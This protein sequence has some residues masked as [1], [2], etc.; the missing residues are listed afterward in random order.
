MNKWQQLTSLTALPLLLFVH[1]CTATGVAVVGSATGGA[2]I[3]QDGRTL[4]SMVEDQGIEFRALLLV[5]DYPDLHQQTH[6]NVTSYNRML[7]IT[8][9]ASTEALKNQAQQI[10]STIPNLRKIYNEL[11]ISA[12]SSLLTRASDS[13]LTTKVKSLLLANKNIRANK[14]KIVSENGSLYLL[15]LVH[16]GEASLAT[17]IARKTAGVQKVVTLFEFQD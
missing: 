14:I 17:D 4:G 7:L 15:G 13:Y 6:I 2:V 9:E 11:Q 16:R 10:F 3:A 12:P 1:G 8:G 5:R